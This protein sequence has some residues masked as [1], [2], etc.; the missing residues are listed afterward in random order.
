MRAFRQR[1]VALN[2]P[3]TMV[4]LQNTVMATGSTATTT[5]P[6]AA[7]SARSGFHDGLH[8][9]MLGALE[10][11][12]ASGTFANAHKLGQIVPGLVVEDVGLIHL[13]LQEAQAKQ[14]IAKARQAPYGK[15]S[16]TIVDTSVRNTWELD[17]SQFRLTN[18]HW[19]LLI[20]EICQT[21]S[22]EAG[23]G[24]VPVQADMYKM[25]IYERGAMF[26]AHTE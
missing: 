20:S 4:G 8:N 16:E 9:D 7:N 18:A 19:P 10:S 13:P 21:I 11:I 17:P 12:R 1:N 6:S 15:G 14:I 26:K 2:R 25:L 23:L 22:V 24:D 5:R 3:A